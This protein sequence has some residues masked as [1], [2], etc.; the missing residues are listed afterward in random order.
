VT[1]TRV[2]RRQ[3]GADFF[4]R[5]RVN[6]EH[7]WAKAAND[8]EG[9]LVDALSGPVL[10][11]SFRPRLVRDA[12]R[13]ARGSDYDFSINID[14][15]RSTSDASF[16]DNGIDTSLPSVAPLRG[17]AVAVDAQRVMQFLLILFLTAWAALAVTLFVAEV[18]TNAQISDLQQHGVPVEVTVG[19]CSGQLGGSG[20][21]AA[22]Y[23]CKGRFS[24]GGQRYN[25]T[26]PGVDFRAPGTTIQLVT[27]KDNPGLIA[28]SRQ[29]RSERDS[30]RRFILPTALLVG[31]MTLVA[32]VVVR[33]G[34]LLQRSA[35]SV[36]GSTLW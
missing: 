10:G 9:F 33:R 29:V 22:A 13:L 16:G 25:D 24:L 1:H 34:R 28:T 20:S 8:R 5:A 21:T 30:M 12:Y 4:T 6:A 27:A 7:A 26:I 32:E 36:T 18:H 31:L 2:R 3:H 14:S 15:Q 17:A 35:Y 11:L 23:I 19:T